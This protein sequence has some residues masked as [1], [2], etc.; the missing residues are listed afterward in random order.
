MNYSQ[1]Y[2]DKIDE[3]RM[4]SAVQDLG[5]SVGI[6]D[7]EFLGRASFREGYN[8]KIEG[9]EDAPDVETRVGLEELGDVPLREDGSG[10]ALQQPLLR[11]GNVV[12]QLGLR[13][14]P[15]A[16]PQHVDHV[17]FRSAVR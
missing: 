4:Y 11:S 13:L 8:L 6:P 3:S 1:T 17:L 14:E 2:E 12:D 5:E 10:S 15:V 9:L 16:R 7:P